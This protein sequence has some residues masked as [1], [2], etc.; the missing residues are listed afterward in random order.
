LL[1]SW[2]TNY[3]YY[4][5]FF[6]ITRLIFAYVVTKYSTKRPTEE[7][8]IYIFSKIEIVFEVL[9]IFLG[10][11]VIT[12]DDVDDCFNEIFYT[13]LIVISYTIVDYFHIAFDCFGKC[14]RFM[15]DCFLCTKNKKSN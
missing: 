3:T 14:F 6:Y 15:L 11:M 10:F 1:W 5:S 9:M 13:F 4:K 7:N 12:K 2:L 8:F